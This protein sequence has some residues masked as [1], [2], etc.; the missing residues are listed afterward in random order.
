MWKD[1]TGLAMTNLD[2]S[3]QTCQVYLVKALIA[4]LLLWVF[5]LKS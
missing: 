2:L 3:Q 4:A 1:L 5:A